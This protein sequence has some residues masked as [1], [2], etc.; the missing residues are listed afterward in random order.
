MRRRPVKNS[1]SKK[2]FRQTSAPH[3]KNLASARKRGGTRLS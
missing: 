1:V 2:V 3:P